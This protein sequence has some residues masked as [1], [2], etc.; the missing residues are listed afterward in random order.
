MARTVRRPA[1]WAW[2]GGAVGALLVAVAMIYPRATGTNMHVNWEPLHAYWGPRITPTSVLPVL[3]AVSVLLLWPRVARLRWPAFLTALF[4]GTWLWTMSLAW[5]DGSYGIARVFARTGWYVDDARTVDSIP[6]MLSGYV[7]RIPYSSP[8]H[9]H[10]HA[11]GHPPGALLFFVL[12]DRLGLTD[13]YWIGVLVLT[14]GCTAVVA[15]ALVLRTLGGES[16]ARRAG[17]WWVLA[18]AAIWI[19][20]SA[21]A[22][23]M[24]VAAWGLALLAFS[25]TATRR[26]R[27]VGCAVGAGLVLGYCVYLSY[28]LPLLGILA[29]SVLWLARRWSPLPWA[30]G[31]ALLVVAAFTLAG[32]AWWDAY[33]V[34]VERYYAGLGGERQFG[35]WVWA[36]LA[37]WT[38]TVGLATWAA[39]PGALARLGARNVVATLGTA[40]LVSIGLAS[41][42]GMSKAEVERIWLPFTLWILA[43][44]AL[45][46]ERWHRPLL[47]TQVVLAI[48][49]QHLVITRW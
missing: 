31:G 24:A 30:V 14:L 4:A 39:I 46:P 22:M 19:G 12:L 1:L 25:A 5:V 17:P 3:V 15:A 42:S 11:S 9:W 10:L 7:G 47:V 21:D 40:G 8:D 23:F 35:Y 20:V 16:W 28:G 36:D 45:L 37:A 13:P 29:L 2:S 44:P 48:V 26:T 49:I 6:A 41:L 43:L 33:P 18:P 32:F 38:F 34:L 27:L